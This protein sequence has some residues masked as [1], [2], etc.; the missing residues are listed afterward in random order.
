MNHMSQ[1]KFSCANGCCYYKI[2]PYNS[3]NYLSKINI[4]VLNNKIKKSGC[5]IHSPDKDKVLLVQSRGQMWGCPKGSV[6]ENEET[7]DCAI[8][9]VKEETGI[10]LKRSDLLYSIILDEKV[11]YFPLEMKE[12]MVDIQLNDDSDANDANGIGWFNVECLD[13][14]VKDGLIN[15]N[16]HCRL[17]IK[18]IIKKTISFNKK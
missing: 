10:D 14:L 11:E 5:F 9:E 3:N 17:L 2:I 18:K 12:C 8:R 13:D 16:Q 6:K 4:N 15:I 1:Q 7:I